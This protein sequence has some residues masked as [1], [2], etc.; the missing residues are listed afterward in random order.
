MKQGK[1]AS[2]L[3]ALSVLAPVA[4]SADPVEDLIRA[5]MARSQTPGVAVAVVERG[6][7]VRVQGFGEANVEDGAPVRADTLF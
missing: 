3:L 1:L 5:E 4:A 6:H 2:L 7:I